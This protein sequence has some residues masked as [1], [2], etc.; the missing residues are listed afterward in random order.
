MRMVRLTLAYFS[1]AI[2]SLVVIP[3]RALMA[4]AQKYEGKQVLTIQFDPKEQPLDPA[5]LHDILPLQKDQPLRMADV[6]ASIERLF[7]TGRYADI[8]VDAEPYNDGTR[9]GVIVRFLTRNSWFIGAVTASGHISNPPR[10]GQLENASG[11]DLGQPYTSLKLQEALAGQQRLLESNGLYHSQIKTAFDYDQDYQQVNIR[12]DIA[13]G[14]RARFAMPILQG[15][16]K[17]DPQRI[18]KATR[19]RRWLLNT[20]KPMT[21]TRVQRALDDVRLLYQRENRLEA[22]VS[23]ESMKYDPATNTAVPTLQI[24]AGPRIQVNTIGANIS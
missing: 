6:H 7:A 24:E 17:L 12:F 4:Q 14:P 20:W 5:E 10:P 9:D 15:D 16:V 23:L 13:S 3:P 18:L 11:L 2:L 1:C 8:Q 21:Q 22:R 19:F